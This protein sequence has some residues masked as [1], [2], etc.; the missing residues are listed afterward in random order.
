MRS[1]GRCWPA[2]A[3]TDGD[4]FTGMP[5]D[6]AWHFAALTPAELATVRYIDYDYWTE[7][8]GGTRWPP[9]ARPQARPVAGSAALVNAPADR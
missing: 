1:G 3:T 6:V 4:A 2:T 5:A 9:T 7:F 8:P